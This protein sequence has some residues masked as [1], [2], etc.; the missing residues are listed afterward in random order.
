MAA[1]RQPG[2][3]DPALAGTLGGIVAKWATFAP[4][5]LFIFI[6]APYV[7][8]LRNNRAL[9]AVLSTIM[10][11]VV[12][13]ILNLAVWFAIHTLFAQVTVKHVLGMTLQIPALS[14]LD[15]GS[16]LLSGAAMLALFRFKLGMMTTLAGC[17]IAGIV[18]HMIG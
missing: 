1:F 7:E 15:L 12:G 5:F 16:L 11:A 10:A 13:V 9:N 18:I 8:A 3:L 14:S 4:S 2:T 6:G 17:C